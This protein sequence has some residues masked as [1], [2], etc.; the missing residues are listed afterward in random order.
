[1]QNA[2]RA[3]ELEKWEFAPRELEAATLAAHGMWAA[4]ATVAEVTERVRHAE[5]CAGGDVRERTRLSTAVGA[6]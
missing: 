4:I 5:Q 3:G 1:M 2:R 6:V